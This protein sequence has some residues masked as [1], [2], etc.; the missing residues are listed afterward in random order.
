MEKGYN[1]EV[2]AKPVIDNKKPELVDELVGD[3]LSVNSMKSSD[4]FS[5]SDSELVAKRDQQRQYEVSQLDPVQQSNT[6]EELEV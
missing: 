2:Y 5:D 3:T 6:N 4:L 1:L